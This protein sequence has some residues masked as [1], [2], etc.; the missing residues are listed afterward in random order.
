MT[1][2]FECT[3][4][5]RCCMGMGRYVTVERKMSATQYLCRHQLGKEVFYATIERPYRD[6][7]E[8]GEGR[9]EA[10]CPFLM[11]QPD[12]TGHVCIVHA[13]RPRFCREYRCYSVKID[14]PAGE[15][16]GRV[17]GRRTLAT[18]DARLEA[19]WNERVVPLTTADDRRWREEVKILL[20]K[21]GY[22]VTI[23]D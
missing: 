14:D 17:K 22:R 10:W 16:A 5:G 9:E 1:A 8:A 3:L 15:E 12:G 6:R 13:T 20:E 18:G 4:C 7:F 19:I 21:E 11:Q 2:A 23:V